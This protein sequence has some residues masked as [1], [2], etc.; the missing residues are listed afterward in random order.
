MEAQNCFICNS[1]SV[2]YSRNLFKIKSKHSQTRLCDFIAKILGHLPTNDESNAIDSDENF[3]CFECLSKIDD[4]DLA[5]ETAKKAESELRELLL[6]AEKLRLH[7]LKLEDIKEVLTPSI[8]SAVIKEEKFKIEDLVTETVSIHSDSGSNPDNNDVYD[9][10]YVPSKSTSPV[11]QKKK[12]SIKLGGDEPTDQEYL[13][14]ICD[15]VFR[16]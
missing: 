3:V 12:V 9:E 15:E 10:D 14:N 5:C 16:R 11:K 1:V 7:S 8:E 6:T 2:F 13:C 4:Y